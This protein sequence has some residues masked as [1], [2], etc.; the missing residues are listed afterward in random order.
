VVTPGR[1]WVGRDSGCCAPCRLNSGSRPATRYQSRN[2]GAR[3][4]IV[5]RIGHTHDRLRQDGTD[6]VALGEQL[7]REDPTVYS[8]FI[9]DP[10]WTERAFS[11]YQIILS[12]SVARD[13]IGRTLSGSQQ[14]GRQRLRQS[15]T[16]PDAE[17]QECAITV[18]RAPDSCVAR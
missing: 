4:A 9:Q 17:M 1:G 3:N 16:S 11:D 10:Y 5:V 6:L 7:I 12:G 15:R 18:L 13:R 2:R 14:S 8:H